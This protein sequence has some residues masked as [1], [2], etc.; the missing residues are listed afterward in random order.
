MRQERVRGAR[1]LLAGSFA[2]AIALLLGLW[3]WSSLASSASLSVSPTTARQNDTVTLAGQGFSPGETVAVWITYPDFRVYG[4]AELTANGDGAFSYPYLPDFLGATFTPTGKYTYTAHGKDSGR[5]VYADL[6]VNIGAAP[7]A[8][9]GVTL[10]AEPGRDSQGSYFIFRGS[11]YWGGEDVAVWLRYPDN[12]VEDLGQVSAGPGGSIEYV[13][14]VT[15]VPVGHYAL[16]ARGTLSGANGIAEFDVTVDDLTVATGKASLSVSPS[17][18]HQRSFATFVGSGFQPKE[19]VT[20]WVTLPDY[21]TLWIGDVQADE[22][23]SFIAVLYLS[24]QEPVGQRSFT[25]YGNTSGLR[26]V[27]TYTLTPG[28]GPGDTSVEGGGT[29]IPPADAVCVGEGCF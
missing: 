8:S 5:E 25:A 29:T 13:L 15:G 28:S 16:T 21:S 2:G 17:P 1:R 24:E 27:A 7:G 3:S 11:G 20:V 14:Y 26:A 19:I 4:V 10:T 12:T 23:G 9:A 18:D 6:N 22:G